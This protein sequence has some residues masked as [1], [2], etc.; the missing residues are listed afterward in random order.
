[1]KNISPPA[2]ASPGIT[3]SEYH[4]RMVAMELL[5]LGFDCDGF[6][7]QPA[8]ERTI[9][10]HLFRALRCTCLVPET[11]TYEELRYT[12]CGRTD[13]GVSAYRQVIALRVRS[14]A[15]LTEPLPTEAEELDYPTLLNKNMPETVRVTSWTT[16]ADDFNARYGATYREYKYFFTKTRRMDV[17]RMARA[18]SFLEGEHD[19]RNFCKVNADNAT[20]LVR[21]IF[22]AKIVPAN[23]AA[24]VDRTADASASAAAAAAGESEMYMLVIRGTGFL[25]HMIRCIMAV[26]LMVGEGREEPEIVRDLLDMAQ[27]EGQGKPQYPLAAPEPLT[28]ADCGFAG[29]VFPLTRAAAR[30]LR[31]LEEVKNAL[32]ARAVVA[33]HA[34]ET[35]RAS[36]VEAARAAG[37]GAEA[38]ED[39]AARG[40]RHVPLKDRPREMPVEERVVKLRKL[41][42]LKAPGGARE[43]EGGRGEEA[44][45]AAIDDQEAAVPVALSEVAPASLLC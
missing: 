19:F 15:R 27:W 17:E 16:V 8:N 45:I 7:C 23:D 5:Y 40:P 28:L 39:E 26:L 44:E 34:Y 6:A 22:Y 18:A 24:E 12:R 36:Y 35:V 4:S 31:E 11:S 20:N 25:W 2:Y 1:M 14:K 33:A 38:L 29:L 13:K 43:G 10:A 42:T 30:T 41:G 21:K 32:A 3:F 9:E 37:M